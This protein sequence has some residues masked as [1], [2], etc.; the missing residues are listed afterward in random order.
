MHTIRPP[1]LCIKR[2]P[3]CPNT[4]P[5]PPL[6]LPR[7]T[8]ALSQQILAR[9][10]RGYKHQPG[11][12]RLHTGAHIVAL[13]VLGIVGKVHGALHCARRYVRG[14]GLVA[15]PGKGV[16]AVKGGGV[17]A[18]DHGDEDGFVGVTLGEGGEEGLDFGVGWWGARG[19]GVVVW[20]TVVGK[21]GVVLL[22]AG[23]FRGL[24]FGEDSH[25]CDM[26][27]GGVV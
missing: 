16:E 11:I 2:P 19:A 15:F 22:V 8:F 26:I 23:G 9:P 13:R 20:G 18:H 12:G 1:T 14:S 27:H 21:S 4:L 24:G 25:C 3:K 5:P 7:N 10:L 17:A 6:H